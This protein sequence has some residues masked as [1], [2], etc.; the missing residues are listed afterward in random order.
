MLRVVSIIR[1]MAMTSL[2]VRQ[3]VTL[4]NLDSEDDDIVEV[5][6]LLQKVDGVLE[7]SRSRSRHHHHQKPLLSPDEDSDNEVK[8]LLEKAK[9]VIARSRSPSH[10]REHGRLTSSNE[11]DAMYREMDQDL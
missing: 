8:L 5:K 10:H 7:R 6:L 2:K 11:D 1:D 3:R 4:V 9:K